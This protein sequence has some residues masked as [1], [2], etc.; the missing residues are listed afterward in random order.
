VARN[1]LIIFL[2]HKPVLFALEPILI[3]WDISRGVRSLVLVLVCVPG[4]GLL[5]EWLRRTLNVRKLRDHAY[6]RL[7]GWKAPLVAARP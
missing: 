5:S 6:Q 2:A 7:S 1:T 3:G 4:L